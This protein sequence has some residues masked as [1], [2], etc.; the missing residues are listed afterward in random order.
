MWKPIKLPNY[1][2]I[3]NEKYSMPEYMHLVSKAISYKYLK[4]DNTVDIKF[5]AK[6]PN[7]PSGNS[8]K[9]DFSKNNYY[10]IAKRTYLYIEKYNGAPNYI[11]SASGKI[12]YQTMI[13][14][15]SKIGNYIY[16]NNKLPTFL[17]LNIKNSHSMNKN[18]P[19]YVRT[20]LNSNSTNS[21]SGNSNTITT[22]NKNAVWVH[23]GDMKNVN[24]DTLVENGIG[25]IFIHEDIFKDKNNALNWISTATNK[26]IKIHIWFTCF[27]NTSTKSWVNPINTNTK[28]YN[29]GYFNNIINRAKEY[30]SYN[31]VAGIHLDYLRYPGSEK[32]SP[33]PA[34]WYSYSNGITGVNAITE[35]TKQIS[36][37]LKAMNNKL[38]ISAA[39]MPET[40]DNAKYYGQ[41]PVQLGKYL[42]VICPM[43]YKGN[44]G[45]SSSWIA[46]TTQW[47]VK[48]SGNAEIW[49]ALQ[50]YKDDNNVVKLSA[51]EL[52]TDC[53]AA[54]SGGASGIALFRWGLINIFNILNI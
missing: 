15:F 39:I 36:T 8:I 18:I 7:K 29:Q 24:L 17:G 50:S 35:F 16:V 12:Q 31:G 34:Y 30:T 23:S 40:T 44:Y 42:D 21:N 49:T 2:T 1:V 28:T 26:G 51:S 25:N 47:Y 38:I 14:G 32:I 43:I 9:K 52:L 13:Y 37:S 54:L 46:T 27:Y 45:K 41:D 48:N 4:S 10:D 3:S 33:G 11:T 5:N 6:N 22:N 53:K 19:K 20:T